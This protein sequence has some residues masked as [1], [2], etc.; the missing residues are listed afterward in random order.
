M[1]LPFDQQIQLAWR[2][3]SSSGDREGWNTI[4]LYKKN[5]WLLVTG[6]SLS[7]NEQ[8]IF[9]EINYSNISISNNSLPIAQGFRVQ[10]L[11]D[12]D[13][14]KGLA[15]IRQVDGDLELFT[16]MAVDVCNTIIQNET[17]NES[18]LISLFINRINAWLSFMRKGFETL[19]QEAELGLIG[20][21]ETLSSLISANIPISDVLDAWIG[22]LDGLKDFELGTGAIEIKSTLSSNG[23]IAKI[24]SLEQLDDSQISPLFINGYR[25]SINATGL[26]LVERINL[27]RDQLI[28]FPS[29]L[30]RLNNLLLRVGYLETAAENYIRRFKTENSYFWLVDENFPRLVPGNIAVNIRQV[31]YE[32]DLTPLMNDSIN[33]SIVLQ[34]LGIGNSGIN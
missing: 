23:F 30:S 19:S 12:E 26:T 5:N 14:K 11:K 13:S 20:E 7:T 2:A 28:D 24:G 31:K 8:A 17:L 1:A 4:P 25:F 33:L 34:K 16:K 10:Q 15:L 21:L 9:L 27:L 6:C 29:E 3:L 18:Q 32:I 22:P